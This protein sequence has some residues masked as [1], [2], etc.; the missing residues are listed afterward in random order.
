MYKVEFKMTPKIVTK[1]H[2]LGIGKSRMIAWINQQDIPFKGMP[3]GFADVATA[4]GLNVSTV[5]H[6]FEDAA[7]S[8]G[9]KYYVGT[10]SL[11]GVYLCLISAWNG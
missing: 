9:Y 8:A 10:K 11:D 1:C 6:N 3:V 4:T 5:R 2:R 7:L